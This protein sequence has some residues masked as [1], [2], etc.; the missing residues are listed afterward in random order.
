MIHTH[1]HGPALAGEGGITRPRPARVSTRRV[2]ES[3]GPVVSTVTTWIAA[4]FIFAVT[5]RPVIRYLQLAK[6]L[7]RIAGTLMGADYGIQ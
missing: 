5:A 4:S 1:G 7:T 2:L 3:I 6:W